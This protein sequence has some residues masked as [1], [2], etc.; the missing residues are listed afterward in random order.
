[1]NWYADDTELESGHGQL[2]LAFR[3]EAGGNSC[4]LRTGRSSLGSDGA[5][6]A[7]DELGKLLGSG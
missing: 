7:D 1:M 6:V 3:L 4:D 5:T 2:S